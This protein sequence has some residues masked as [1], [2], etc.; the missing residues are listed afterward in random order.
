MKTFWKYIKLNVRR[1]TKCI[2]NLFQYVYR[3]EVY[4]LQKQ[5]MKDHQEERQ[6]LERPLQGRLDDVA[7]EGETGHP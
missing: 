6:R 2:Q 7:A 1:T 4:R 3:M 5:N